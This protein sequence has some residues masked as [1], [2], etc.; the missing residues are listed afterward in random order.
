MDGQSSFSQYALYEILQ[1][2]VVI[3]VDKLPRTTPIYGNIIYNV[4][5][6]KFS[7]LKISPGKQETGPVLPLVTLGGPVTPD[8]GLNSY[9][10]GNRRL[11]RWGKS[12]LSVKIF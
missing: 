5:W 3:R 7:W 2:W 12:F 8:V 1:P 11:L 4:F 10:S 9:D 6:D